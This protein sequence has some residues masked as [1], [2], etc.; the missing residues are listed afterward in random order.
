[1]RCR[2]KIKNITLA[3]VMIILVMSM[4]ACEKISV[5]V[6]DGENDIVSIEEVLKKG[7]FVKKINHYR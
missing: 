6:S 3:M 5:S 7:E 4:F 2:E 1:M